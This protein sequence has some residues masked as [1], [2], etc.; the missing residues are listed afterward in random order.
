MR[1]SLLRTP[2][3]PYSEN[4]TRFAFV[5]VER[6]M[7]S[8]VRRKTALAVGG[9]VVAL[10]FPFLPLS[11]WENEFAGVGHLIGYEAI[12]WVV[13]VAL[14]VYV[15]FA[16]RR[17]LSSVGF[18]PLGVKNAFIGIAGGVVTV[19]GLGLIYYVIFPLF[20]LNET[21]Q[22]HQLLA[23][24]YWWRFISVI[25]AAVGEEVLYRGYTIERLRELTRSLPLA[26]AVSWVAFTF[27][28]V[29]PWGWNH[30]IVA[31]FGGAMLT[32]LYA[33]RRNLWVNM[34]A[35]FVIDGVAVLS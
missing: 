30:L 13:I 16:E 12:W 4:A 14:L 5:H 31:G 17:P 21:E 9:V 23:T 28:H 27:A 32:L 7:S 19:A 25:R 34:I 11:K 10:G 26:A 29:G 35:H 3:S 24:P 33:W 8:T 1:R 22:M 15:R 6:I 2:R 18:H 20:R